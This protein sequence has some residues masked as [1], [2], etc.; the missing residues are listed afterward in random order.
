MQYV[1]Y[2]DSQSH[3]QLITCGVPQG[4][5]LGPLLFL[6]YINDLAHV[7]TKLFTLLF[8]DDSN[9]FISGSDLNEMI[10]TMNSEMVKTMEWLQVNRLSLNLKKTHFIIFR[11]KRSKIKI[12]QDLVI[13]NVK[14]GVI[15]EK[16]EIFF[17]LK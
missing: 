11:K 17:T 15:Q 12:D 4:S 1:E 6:L 13:N 10:D 8:A 16:F 3:E 9:L 2:G 7:S 14:I 5:I